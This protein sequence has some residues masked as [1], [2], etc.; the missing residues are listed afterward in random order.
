MAQ[1]VFQDPY[2]SLHPSHTV[3]QTLSEPVAIH[4][5]RRGRAGSPAL[6]KVGSGRGHRFRY[7]SR[8]SFPAASASELR[9]RAR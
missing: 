9:S 6:A 8:I 7:R 1:M 3:D 2:G 4:R 5:P